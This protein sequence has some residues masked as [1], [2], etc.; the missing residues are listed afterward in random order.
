MPYPRLTGIV[1]SSCWSLSILCLVKWPSYY[2]NWFYPDTY[3][4]HFVPYHLIVDLPAF[5]KAPTKSVHLLSCQMAIRWRESM[6]AWHI[7][8]DPY[9]IIHPNSTTRC[10]VYAFVISRIS[11]FWQHINCWSCLSHNKLVSIMVRGRKPKSEAIEC[12]F[13]GSKVPEEDDKD[14]TCFQMSDP[15]NNVSVYHK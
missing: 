15:E 7:R 2:V 8:K 9:V 5:W 12:P 4:R 14:D 6:L 10:R 3:E 1:K 11:R 13:C